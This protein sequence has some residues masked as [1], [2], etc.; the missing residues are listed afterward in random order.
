LPGMIPGIASAHPG[1]AC[2]PNC[3][4][5]KL[6]PIFT[7][8]GCWWDSGPGFVSQS[9]FVVMGRGFP[10]QVSNSGG[11]RVRIPAARMAS[12]L[13]VACRPRRDEGAGKTGCT[14]HP[15]SR[16]Q[17]RT[18]DAHT[19]IQVQAEHPGLPC[20]VALRLTSCSPR[21]T[22]LLPPSPPRSFASLGL[23]ASTATSGP[24]DFAV[25]SSHTR[26]SQLS[27]P[28]HPTARS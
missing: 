1:H 20:A 16:V 9:A 27:R 3:P 18:E 19:S 10:I 24:H 28:P 7:T 13:C 26:Q 14:L 11:M 17:L 25:R 4:L 2:L 5:L 22:A 23:N 8:F 12:G 21:R 15:R 6:E